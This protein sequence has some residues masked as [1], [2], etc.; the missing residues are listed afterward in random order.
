MSFTHE[1]EMRFAKKESLKQRAE[2]MQLLHDY[3]PIS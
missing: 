1:L 2:F 3:A